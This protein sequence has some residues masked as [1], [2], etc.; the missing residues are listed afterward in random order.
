M[1][2]SPRKSVIN[3]GLGDILLVSANSCSLRFQHVLKLNVWPTFDTF[4]L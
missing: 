3:I 1:Y 2:R 4:N